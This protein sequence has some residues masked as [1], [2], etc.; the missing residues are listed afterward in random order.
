[1]PTCCES[2]RYISKRVERIDTFSINTAQNAADAAFWKQ[3][4]RML[5]DLT[6]NLVINRTPSR[7]ILS[8]I[9]ATYLVTTLKFLVSITDITHFHHSKFHIFKVIFSTAHIFGDDGQDTEY[10]QNEHFYRSLVNADV[11]RTL[12]ENYIQRG[13]D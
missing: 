9:G 5:E 11:S 4:L 13:Y 6:R 1:M 3:M 8:N 2:V 10:E 7:A 12:K